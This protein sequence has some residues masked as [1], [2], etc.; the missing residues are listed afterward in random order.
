MRPLG[1]AFQ[2]H[3]LLPQGDD[4]KSQVMTR[5]NKASQPCE[6]TPDQPK[7]E[8]VLITRLE[9]ASL[10]SPR[11][12]FGDLQRVHSYASGSE[13]WPY[14]AAGICRLQGRDLDQT[15][16]AVRE[17][18][19]APAKSTESKCTKAERFR[20]HLNILTEMT[21]LCLGF[22]VLEGNVSLK[23]GTIRVFTSGTKNC[24]S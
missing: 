15:N 3:Q 23:E 2:N 17:A 19:Q 14:C 11:P 4:F 24:G 16:K 13:S 12:C 21:V 8:S 9:G 22:N 18:A 10:R 6:H 7:H 5:P 1:P 20:L